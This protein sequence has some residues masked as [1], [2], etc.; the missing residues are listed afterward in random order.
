[1]TQRAIVDKTIPSTAVCEFCR[2]PIGQPVWS[3]TWH[4]A[5]TGTSACQRTQFATPAVAAVTVERIRELFQ[6]AYEHG[7]RQGGDGECFPDNQ[8]EYQSDQLLEEMGLS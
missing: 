7:Y 3:T 1:M 4:H 5:T 6:Q 8:D 2:E